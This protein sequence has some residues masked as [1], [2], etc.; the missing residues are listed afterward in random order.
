[1]KK[2]LVVFALLL[3]TTVQAEWALL[4]GTDGSQTYV[5]ASTLKRQGNLVSVHTLANYVEPIPKRRKSFWDV[6]YT[7][8]VT[9]AIY[10][11]DAKSY[12]NLK[13][14]KYTKPNGEGW[15]KESDVNKN[16]W[17]QLVPATVGWSLM[18]Y[19]CAKSKTVP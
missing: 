2:L 11:C 18:E 8:E 19:V 9:D 15:E 1:M 17:Y 16:K 3:C 7:S 5:E 12:K 4:N 10:D 6:Q 13:V 14:T